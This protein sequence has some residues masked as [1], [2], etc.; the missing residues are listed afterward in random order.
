MLAALL[1]DPGRVEFREIATPVP[2]A[3]EVLVRPVRAGVCGSDLSLFHGHRQPPAY[4]FVL[5]HEVVGRIAGVGAGVSTL[6]VGQ[7]VIVE[8]NYPCGTCRFCMG[9]RGNICPAKRSMGVTVPGCYAE[10]VTA[11]AQF[12][13]PIPDSVTDADAASIEPLAVALHAFEQSGARAG[14]AVGILGCGVVGLLLAH[15]AVARGVRVL[16]SDRLEAKQD[17]AARLGASTPPGTDIASWWAREEVACVFECAG[18]AETA[19]RAIAWAPRGSTVV[20]LGLSTAPA[21]FVP[22]RLVREGVR[23]EPSLIYDHPAGFEEAIRLVDQRVL[24]PSAIVTDEFPLSAT[25]AA[26][27]AASLGDSGKVHILYG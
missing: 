17:M 23:I 6:A 20:L 16:A 10:F 7:R 2:S 3:R 4:P 11:P 25:H 13:W 21:S 15:V 18:A 22:L 27:Q 19:E 9:G 24:R 1:L 14:E 5:G 26:L 12:T 8:P